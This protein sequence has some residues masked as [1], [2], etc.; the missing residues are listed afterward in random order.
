M[1][2]VSHA[3]TKSLEIDSQPTR[4]VDTILEKISQCFDVL[5][6]ATRKFNFKILTYFMLLLFFYTRRFMCSGSVK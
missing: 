2:Y 3:S 4:L 1:V 5:K 6:N